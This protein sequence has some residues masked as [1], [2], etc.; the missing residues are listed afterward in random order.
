MIKGVVL[1]S[2]TTSSG[3]IA[4]LDFPEEFIP[5]IGMHLQNPQTKSVWEIIGISPPIWTESLSGTLQSYY[6][7]DRIWE[8][9]LKPV[10][11]PPGLSSGE[12]LDVLS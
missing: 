9:L 10:N 11:Y 8:C 6:N 3:K 4:V 1:D 12:F 2:A 7:S 5:R